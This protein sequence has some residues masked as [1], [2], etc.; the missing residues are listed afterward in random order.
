MPRPKK[1]KVKLPDPTYLISITIG[2][3]TYEGRGDTALEALQNLKKPEKIM[4]KTI[5]KISEGQRQVEQLMMP[6]RARRLFHPLAR[7]YLAEQFEFLLKWT[8]NSIMNYP[9][10]ILL[11]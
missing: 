1:K 11:W 5:F 7:R 4:N 8:T 3:K 9:T 6:L 10:P 2:D